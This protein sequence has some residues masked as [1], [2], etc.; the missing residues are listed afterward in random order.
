MEADELNK[1]GPKGR[2]FL[3]YQSTGKFFAFL[4]LLELSFLQY[5]FAGALSPIYGQSGN[6]ALKLALLHPGA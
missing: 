5:A 3:L 1:P 6:Q 2:A 4:P